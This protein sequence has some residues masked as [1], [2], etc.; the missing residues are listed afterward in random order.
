MVYHALKHEVGFLQLVVEEQIVVRELHC[1]R[2]GVLLCEVGP[3]HV[4]SG[5][6]PATAGALLVVNALF[7]RL[8]AEI[9]VYGTLVG[10]V[11][12]NV[13]N[14]VRS[15]RVEYGF[16]RRYGSM[17]L[18]HAAQHVGR[19]ASVALLCSRRACHRQ[20]QTKSQISF[21]VHFLL[22]FMFVR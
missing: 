16:C 2:V 1:Q 3:Q 8:V 11:H 22:Y 13:V 4:E 12:C 19:Y 7:R 10:K 15:H 6:H 17:S 14:L 18:L 5:E 21:L 20:A 9:R